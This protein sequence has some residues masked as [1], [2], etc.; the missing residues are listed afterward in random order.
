VNEGHLGGKCGKVNLHLVIPG[1][2]STEPENGC[3]AWRRN[4]YAVIPAK[5]GIHNHDVPGEG[6]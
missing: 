5:A 3:G 2:R 6:E 1:L 4:L